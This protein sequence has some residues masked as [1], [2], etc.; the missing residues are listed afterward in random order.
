MNGALKTTW[1]TAANADLAGDMR[2]ALKKIKSQ[3]GIPPPMHTRVSFKSE[4]DLDV[5]RV[6]FRLP[7]DVDAG[8]SNA[9]GIAG[10]RVVIDPT[11]PNLTLLP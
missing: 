5:Y 6:L 2:D 11:K 7:E 9:I 8:V 3:V 10:L 4:A 1:A